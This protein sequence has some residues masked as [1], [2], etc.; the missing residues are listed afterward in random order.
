MYHT[1]I[2]KS[3]LVEKLVR[4]STSIEGLRIT[5][6]TEWGWPSSLTPVLSM[7]RSCGKIGSPSTRPSVK[8]LRSVCKRTSNSRALVTPS[9]KRSHV[10]VDV[11]LGGGGARLEALGTRIATLRCLCDAGIAE[12]GVQAL[13][14]QPVEIV[15]QI[16]AGQE[17]LGTTESMLAEKRADRKPNRKILMQLKPTLHEEAFLLEAP[18]V[19]RQGSGQQRPGS[20]NDLCEAAI[21]ARAMCRAI[22]KMRSY[23]A[24]L[25]MTLESCTDLMAPCISL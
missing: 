6:Q 12:V 24:T 21:G 18:E 3:E 8:D 22:S 5:S 1:F 4:A 15:P 19:V 10:Q 20:L 23:L 2:L 16:A 9:W 17:V 7:M 13:L 25:L 11:A 14:E